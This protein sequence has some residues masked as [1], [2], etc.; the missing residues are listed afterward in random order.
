MPK[1]RMTR[2]SK[3]KRQVKTKTELT[4]EVRDRLYRTERQCFRLFCRSRWPKG[5]KCIYCNSANIYRRKQPVKYRC[6]DCDTGFSLFTGT[7]LELVR[8]PLRTLVLIIYDI[9][10][11]PHGVSIARTS[12]CAGF[13][14]TTTDKLRKIIMKA[15]L[16]D[17]L[18]NLVLGGVLEADETSVRCDKVRGPLGHRSIN[19]WAGGVRERDGDVFIGGLRNR[20]QDSLHAFLRE[21]TGEDVESIFTDGHKGYNSIEYVLRAPHETVNHSAGEYVRGEV[22]ENGVESVWACLK[23]SQHGVHHHYRE[24]YAELYWAERAW[25]LNHRRAGDEFSAL[26][27]LLMEPKEKTKPE[28][29]K[30]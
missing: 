18:R 7:H 3:R 19:R 28:A 8:A 24:E 1:D 25:V 26:I 6:R 9:T 23:R 5:V 11:I 30:A 27:K 22:H 16:R 12:R 14:Y 17:L 10:T 13:S 29:D 2:F 4:W 15:M 21:R 20:S